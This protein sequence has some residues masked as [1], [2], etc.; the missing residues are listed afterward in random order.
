MNRC[1]CVTV[2][3]RFQQIWALV[4]HTFNDYANRC[5]AD[6]L[7]SRG[8]DEKHIAKYDMVEE[9]TATYDQIALFDCD[10][11]IKENA[12]DIFYVLGRSELAAWAQDW[13][14]KGREDL[15]KSIRQH[16]YPDY[17]HDPYFNSGVVVGY[18]NTWKKLIPKIRELMENRAG[19]L[20][21]WMDQTYF[22]PALQILGIKTM[23]LGRQWNRKIDHIGDGSF[24]YHAYGYDF[25]DKIKLLQAAMG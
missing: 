5:S 12:N 24:I 22:N 14:T 1:I 10:M 20:R 23:E 9:A 19:V 3:G 16:L 4:A 17:Q 2:N 15:T 7:I 8:D 11:V 25:G 18:K 21:P 6:L 13:S